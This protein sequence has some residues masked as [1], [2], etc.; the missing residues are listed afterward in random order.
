MPRPRKEL[1][2]LLNQAINHHNSRWEEAAVEFFR[3]LRSDGV[4]SKTVVFGIRTQEQ[5]ERQSPFEALTRRSA[6]T[7]EGKSDE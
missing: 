7:I 5:A 6:I 2:R 4:T 1:R 3:T